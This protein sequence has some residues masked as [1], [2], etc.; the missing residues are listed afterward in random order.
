MPD[1]DEQDEI[2]QDLKTPT[3]DQIRAEA[4]VSK[5]RET[6]LKLLNDKKMFDNFITGFKKI[7][8]RNPLPKEIQTNLKS[9]IEISTINKFIEEIYLCLL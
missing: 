9:K 5:F 8:M 4:V 3:E 2:I 7:N 6:G 1:I